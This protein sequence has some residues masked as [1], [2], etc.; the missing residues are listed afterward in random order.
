MF[1]AGVIRGRKAF[2]RAPERAV[3]IQWEICL[4]HCPCPSGRA[5]RGGAAAGF[6]R[7]GISSGREIHQGIS[8]LRMSFLPAE[9][10]LRGYCFMVLTL[11][12]NSIAYYLPLRYIV[13]DE[14]D[15]CKSLFINKF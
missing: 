5:V 11:S 9:Q 8:M 15:F 6:R 13:Y 4:F 2:C 1:P 7:D 10:D 3:S 14:S 12:C